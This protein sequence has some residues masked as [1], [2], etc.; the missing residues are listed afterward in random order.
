[1]LGHFVF[2]DWV[3]DSGESI[4][5]TEKGVEL[6]SGSLHSG[7][8]FNGELYLDTDTEN[9]VKQALLDGYSP[10]FAMCGENMLFRQVLNI[11]ALIRE[12]RDPRVR[13]EVLDEDM[14][15]RLAKLIEKALEVK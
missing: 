2:Y 11:K 10:V 5:S 3:D 15:E 8:T 13:A 1:M 4:Y 9:E 7:T 12:L 6:S 14:R